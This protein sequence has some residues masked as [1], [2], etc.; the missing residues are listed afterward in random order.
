MQQD[1]IEK[2]V[3]SLGLTHSIARALLLKYGWNADI[4]MEAITTE[5]S[6]SSVFNFD[7]EWAKPNESQEFMCESCYCEY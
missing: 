1:S 3:D 4:A 7:F 6:I 5:N 2:I